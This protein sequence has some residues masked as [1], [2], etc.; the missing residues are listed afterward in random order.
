VPYCGKDKQFSHK[1][2]QQGIHVSL[3]PMTQV[4]VGDSGALVSPPLHALSQ[5]AGGKLFGDP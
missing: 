2:D 4:L 3:L 5:S 1:Q